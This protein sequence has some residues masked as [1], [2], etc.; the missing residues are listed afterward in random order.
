[1][2]PNDEFPKTIY[3][4]QLDPHLA[5]SRQ[6]LKYHGTVVA[7]SFLAVGSP[8]FQVVEEYMNFDILEAARLEEWSLFVGE[9]VA[10]YTRGFAVGAAERLSARWQSVQAD[11][12][13][14]AVAVA[15]AVDVA[16][17]HDRTAEEEDCVDLQ[18]VRKGELV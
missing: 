7:L 4:H 16:A 10:D 6:D 3:Y 13:N 14:Q 12:V 8:N 15:A 1:L 17:R 2:T 5:Y 9:E 11:F 18:W